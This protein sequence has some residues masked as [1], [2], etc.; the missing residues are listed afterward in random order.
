MLAWLKMRYT[1]RR[2]A[3]SLY[4]SIVTAARRRILYADLGVPDTMQGR[5]E[6]ILLHLALTIRRLGIEGGAGKGVAQALTEAFVV[7]MDDV[8]REMTFSDLAVPREIKRA[9]AALFDRHN[10]Y[11]AALTSPHDILLTQALEAQLAY[12]EP[13]GLDAGGLAQYVRRAASALADQSGS[14]ILGGHLAW[15]EPAGASQSNRSRH[16]GRE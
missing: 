14:Q 4:G 6:M 2:T 10:A 9:T 8:M 7:D 5:F 12:L 11:L 16:A 13:A 3:R 1:R 15:P